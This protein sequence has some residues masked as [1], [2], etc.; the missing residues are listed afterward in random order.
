MSYYISKSISLYIYINIMAEWFADK[1][2]LLIMV[3]QIDSENSATGETSIDNSGY[4]K[5]SKMHD[6]LKQGLTL[7]TGESNTNPS[8][9]IPWL[10]IDITMTHY[11]Y[12]RMLRN[13][14]ICISLAMWTKNMFKIR[15]TAGKCSKRLVIITTG[16][17]IA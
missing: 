12:I 14:K 7:F 16:F 11:Y 9:W 10:E 17:G 3:L 8:S 6:V 4:E 13:A 1:F 5:Y 15:W 2:W